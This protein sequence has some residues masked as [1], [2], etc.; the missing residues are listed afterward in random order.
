MEKVIVTNPLVEKTIVS[1]GPSE[2]GVSGNLNIVVG[3]RPTAPSV[4]LQKLADMLGFET[5]ARASSGFTDNSAP[6]SKVCVEEKISLAVVP[7]VKQPGGCNQGKYLFVQH[8]WCY[9][10]KIVKNKAEIRPRCRPAKYFSA[11]SANSKLRNR[12]D[13]SPCFPLGLHLMTLRRH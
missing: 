8:E 5:L 2:E 10:C 12:F 6:K 4:S 7:T 11:P 13:I 1:C 9:A 3:S